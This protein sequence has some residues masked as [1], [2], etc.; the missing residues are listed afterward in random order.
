VGHTPPPFEST[1]RA[2][3][4]KSK[5]KNLKTKEFGERRR[6][7]HEREEESHKFRVQASSTSNGSLLF[8]S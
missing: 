7:P 4:A 2:G 6:K 8:F 1:A 3:D 5:Q